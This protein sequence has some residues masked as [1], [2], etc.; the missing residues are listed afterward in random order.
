MTL[1]DNVQ[2]VRVRGYWYSQTGGGVAKAVRFVP[3]ATDL[4][5]MAQFSYIQLTPVTVTPDSATAY[6]YADLIATND[7]D[8]TPFAWVVMRQGQQPV[9]IT[10]DYASSVVDVGG[11]NMMAAAWLVDCATTT[12][13]AP[14]DTYYTSAQTDAAIA[15][16]LSGISG[17]G[18]SGV[19]SVNTR[20]GAVTLTSSDVGLGSVNNTADTAKPVSTAQQT[21]LNLKQDTSAKGATSGYAGL[22]GSTKVPIAQLPTGSSS[23]TVA[24]GNDSRLS[25]S[26]TP[27]AHK[28][29]HAT[30]GS[31]ALIASDIG[32]AATSHS[33]AESDVTSL[34]SDLSGKQPLDTDLTAIAAL[35]PSNDDVIQRKAGNWTNRT[36]AQ[37]KADLVLTQSDVGL[38]SVNNT[39]DSAKPVSTAQA[40]YA[41]SRAVA[42]AIVLGS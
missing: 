12:A 9:T 38:G 31:D 15:T 41:T 18:S 29:T 21:A 42:L 37:L 27:T 34:T 24:I 22:D 20:T 11:G 32:A 23:S 14:V 10:V 35:T 39:A 7:P 28:S 16:A 8:L 40:A 30:S 4:T 13:P 25:D 6:F 26:R 3:T 33:H 19:S 36:P 5:D 17:G 1:P 2:L